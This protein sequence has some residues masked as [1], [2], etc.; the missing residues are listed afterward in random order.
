MN[1]IRQEFL[2]DISIC[3]EIIKIFKD[4]PNKHIGISSNG[5]NIKEKDS[6]DLSIK[7]DDIEGNIILTNYMNQLQKI[8][9]NYVKEYEY[10]GY[11]TN[12]AIIEPINIQHYKPNQGYHAWHTERSSIVFPASSRHLVFMTYLNDVDDKGETEFYYQQLKIKPEKGKTVIWCA[13]WTHTHRGISSP[14][15]EKYIVTGWYNFI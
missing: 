10:A 6:T 13:D 2:E 8:C 4:A 11:Y 1:F 15:Q 7:I 3:D 14:T 12:W 5:V 9:D